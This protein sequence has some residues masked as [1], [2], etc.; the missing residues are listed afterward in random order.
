MMDKKDNYIVLARKYRPKK[1][2]DILGQEEACSVIE[3]SI[4]L[5]RVAHAFLFSGTRGVGKTTIARILSKMLNCNEPIKGTLDPCESCSNCNSINNESNIDVVE[6]DA[7]SRT[8]V[9]DIREI[10]ENISYKP[11]SAK[12]KIFII[13]EVHMLSKA[14][15]NALLKTLEEPPEDVI[16]IFATTET[17]KI[18][19]TILSRCQRFNLKRVDL[20]KISNHIIH[21]SKNEGY[22][23]D[24]D[25]SNLIAQCSEGS[26][27]DALSILDNVLT[28]SNHISIEV[29]RDVLGL[30]DNSLALNLFKSLFEGDVKLSL[31]QFNDLYSKGISIDQLAKLLMN[32]S[33]NLAMIKSGIDIKGYFFNDK[34]IDTLTQIAENSEMDFI[35]RFWELLQKYVN[36]LSTIFDEKQCFDMTVMRICFASIIPT[37]FE[38]LKKNGLDNG[39]NFIPP[40]QNK[41]SSDLKTPETNN[42]NES[43]A[44]D[45]L[46]RERKQIDEEIKQKKETFQKD[47]FKQFSELVDLIENESEM[48]ISYHLKNSFKLINYKDPEIEDGAGTIE[49]ECNSNNVESKKILWKATKIIEK[50]T[51]KRWVLFI[52]NKKGMKSIAE[53]QNEKNQKLIENVKKEKILKKILEIIPSSEVTSINVVEVN[54]HSDKKD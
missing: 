26:V 50:I 42:V 20:A 18:P 21:I 38:I 48:V 25:A 41:V 11:V 54:E 27:R 52:S 29:V 28:K 16:F 46:A 9:S 24:E 13:D 51:K 1:L 2:S 15:F 17:E 12:K 32:F 36:E 6:I 5:N 30:A 31:E 53:Y 22:K 10:I 33:Y 19:V 37:P 23:I 34:I 7:A 40:T 49:L 43:Y 39:K 14:A 45:N 47:G 4:K 35:T 44:Q 8:G 3:G